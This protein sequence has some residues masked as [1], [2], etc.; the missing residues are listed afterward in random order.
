MLLA[1]VMA[2]LPPAVN[3][4]LRAVPLL[5]CW[6]LRLRPQRGEHCA[7]DPRADAGKP[8]DLGLRGAGEP[9]HRAEVP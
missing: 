4:I 6:R 2:V 7:R 5:V 3:A 9:A 8:G 1:M